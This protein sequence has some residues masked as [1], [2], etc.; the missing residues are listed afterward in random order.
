MSGKIVGGGGSVGGRKSYNGI[1]DIPSGSRKMVQSLKEIVNCPEAEIYAVLKDCNMDPNEAVNRLLS[2]DPF[3]EVKSKKEKKKEIRDIP[4]SRPRGYSNTYNRG[5][6]GGSDRFSGPGRS[7]ATPFSSSESGNFQGKA[8]NKRESEK[9][10][11]AG[12]FSSTSGVSTHHPIPHS[13][14]VAMDRKTPTVTS[15]GGIPSSQTVS[16][17]QTAWCGAAGQMSMADIVKMGRPH[18]K[19][20]T[21]HK[22]VDRRSEVN[23]AHETAANQHVPVKE[24]WPSIEKPMAASTS[25]VS[26]APS[27]SETRTDPADFQSSRGDQYLKGHLE[28]THL[29]ENG[30]LGYLG[31]D[32]VQADTVAGGVV[33]EDESGASSEFADNPYRHQTQNHP[34]EH[35]KDED[36]VSAVA[37]NLQELSIENHEKFS[38]HDED[39]PAVVIPDHLLIHTEECSQLSFGSF[40]GFGSRPLNNNL[41]ETSDV[42]PQIERADARNTEFYGDEHLGNMSNENVVHTSTAENYDESSESQR[43]A[44]LPENPETAHQENQYSFA[45]SDPEYAYENAKQQN[46]AFDASQT[47]MQNQMQN[48]ASLTNVMRGQGYTNSIP[49][50]LLA[51]QS[52]RE[53]ELQYSTFPGVQSMPSRSNDSSLGGQSNSMPEALRGGGSQTTQPSQQNLPPGANIATGPALPQQLPMHPYSQHTVPLAHFA[54]MI[55]YPL[56][57]QSYPYMPS[58]FQQ[59]F[60]G[61]SSYHQSLAALLPQYK[62][63][64][65]ASNVPQSATSA[66]T[67]SAYGFG[68]SSNAGAGNYPLNHQQQQSAPS[69]ASLSYEDALSLQYKQN[70]HLLSLQQQQQLQQQ[71]LQ[72]QQNENSPMWLHGPGSQTMSGVPSNTYYNLQ[73]QQQAQQVRQA[74]QQAQQQQYGSLGYPNYYQSQT[75][76]HQQQNPRDGGSQGQPSKQTQQQQLWQN[77]Y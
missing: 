29:A 23:H 12:S 57:P 27:D 33:Q 71:Q 77:S 40:G 44:L 64:I 22:N 1:S 74:Q 35:Q 59:A 24:E 36:D 75:M 34:V 10:G 58:A 56:M 72:Q 30:P 32:H 42:P 63:N 26:V 60:A 20:T 9:Q 45:Q 43:E 62:N 68:N 66:P 67:S 41:E 73:A 21:S 61:N 28:D 55:G 19:T 5:T 4:D 54:N 11:Y 69:G 3:H 76:E 18:N 51:A 2:Q 14:S 7:G 49:N 6:R 53:L 50:T 52:A 70:N 8:T 25:S 46:T 31:R 65:S 15:G 47:G 38:S 37:A 16:G 17:H 13:D 48:L 39:R